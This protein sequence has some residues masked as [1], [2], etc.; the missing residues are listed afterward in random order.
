MVVSAAV[1]IIVIVVV[2]P[3]SPSV[4]LYLAPLSTG[5]RFISIVAL[6]TSVAVVVTTTCDTSW[7]TLALYLIVPETNL[8]SRFTAVPSLKVSTKSLSVASSLNLRVTL[9]V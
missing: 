2:L 9:I 6:A 3:T 1:T 8:G 4:T 7:A 5:S